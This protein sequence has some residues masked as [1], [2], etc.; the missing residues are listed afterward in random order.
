VLSLP[1]LKD[2]IKI[3]RERN[4]PRLANQLRKLLKGYESVIVV[5][6]TLINDI[7]MKNTLTTLKLNL[8]S[9]K[10]AFASL[11][12]NHRRRSQLR[13]SNFYEFRKLLRGY[14]ATLLFRR[15]ARPTRVWHGSDA[16]QAGAQNC[17]TSSAK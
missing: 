17:A 2:L 14:W 10:K 16:N 11:P 9:K 4:L 12:P 7:L 5:L 3:S 1:G 8:T 13:P 6:K 15:D